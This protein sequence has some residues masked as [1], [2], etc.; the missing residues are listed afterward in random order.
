M[1]DFARLDDNNI[2]INVIVVHNNELLVNGVEVEQAG[3]DFCHNLL[4]GTWV[5]TSSDDN[6]R[7]QYGTIGST[8]DAVANEFISPQPY[9]SWTLDETHDW[10]PPTPMPLVGRW[11]WD[12]ATLV[13]NE[14]VVP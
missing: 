7:K 9:P 10:Q 5:Q 13:W 4:G 11:G 2:V 14:I 6:F 3:I 1:S 12:E 8:Y